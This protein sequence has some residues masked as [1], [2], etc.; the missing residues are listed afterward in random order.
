MS[1]GTTTP[2]QHLISMRCGVSYGREQTRHEWRAPGFRLRLLCHRHL[3]AKPEEQA[4]LRAKIAA[5]RQEWPQKCEVL[6]VDEATVRR[7]LPL[8]TQWCLADDVAEI[9]TGDDHTKAH[10][11]GAVAPLTRRTPYHMGHVLGKAVL[12]TFLRQMLRSYPEKDLWLIHGRAEQH[13]GRPVEVL[14][15]SAKER[16]ILKPQPVYAVF[17]KSGSAAMVEAQGPAR[18]SFQKA[19]FSLANSTTDARPRSRT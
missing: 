5:L 11:Y 6:C 7:Y 2:V 8:A 3:Q 18:G 17:A 13:K 12:A 9:P 19:F 4:A 1:L 14:Q 15:Q 16:L 10:V